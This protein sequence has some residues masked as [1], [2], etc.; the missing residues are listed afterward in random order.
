M[1][2]WDVDDSFGVTWQESLGKTLTPR[3]LIEMGIDMQDQRFGI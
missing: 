2:S 1:C 3:A